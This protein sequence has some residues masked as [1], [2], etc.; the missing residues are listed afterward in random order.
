MKICGVYEIVNLVNSKRYIGSSLDIGGRWKTHIRQLS[1]RKHHSILLQRAWDKYGP[2]SFNF[3]VVEDTSVEDRFAHE[4]VWLDTYPKDQLYNVSMDTQ[5]VGGPRG[6]CTLE[7]KAAIGG[8]NRGRPTG[9]KGGHNTWSDKA[10]ASMVAK[11]PNKV[12]AEHSDGR[13]MEFTHPSQAAKHLGLARKVVS[14]ILNGCAKRTRCGWVF[15][16][17]PK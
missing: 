3:R 11:Y 12:V 8:A 15:R 13:V 2:K 1:K 4:Q 9:K 14:N 16:Y 10:T 6:P 5:V 17:E 7:R